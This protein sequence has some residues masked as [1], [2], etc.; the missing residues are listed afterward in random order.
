MATLTFNGE[1]FTVDHAAKGADYI[2]GYDADGV[3]I[4][5][6][7]GIKDFSGYSYDGAYMNPSDCLAEL[8]NEM[9]YCGGKAKTRGGADIPASA[10]GAAAANHGNHVPQTEAANNARF[11]RNDNTWQTITPANIGALPN[12]WLPSP[13]EIGAAAENHGNH[14]YFQDNTFTTNGTDVTTITTPGK[15]LAVF[16]NFC[17]RSSEWNHDLVYVPTSNRH[18]PFYCYDMIN[19]AVEQWPMQLYWYADNSIGVGRYQGNSAQFTC[20]CR[21]LYVQN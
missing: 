5:S 10:V 19:S 8:C 3:L 13:T 16:I 21:T 4:V 12:T 7:D 1:S 2:H 6:F 11:L 18:A 15:I 14:L 17:G 20:Y 9:V